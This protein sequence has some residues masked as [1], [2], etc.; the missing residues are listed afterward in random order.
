MRI[1]TYIIFLI[2][3][4]IGITF[5]Y[6]NAS[7]VDFNYYLGTKAMPLSLLLT[8]AFGFGILVSFLFIVISWIRLKSKIFRQKKHIQNLEQEISALKVS[9]S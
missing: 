8:L 5:A 4:I 9:T 7:S 2:I 1:I 6:L 3:L